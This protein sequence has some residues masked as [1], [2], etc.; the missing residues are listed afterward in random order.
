MAIVALIMVTAALAAPGLMR[1]MAA[2]RAQ[3]AS[4]DLGRLA[5]QARADSISYGR[6]YLLV[7]ETGASGRMELWRGITDSCRFNRWSDIVVAGGCQS[8]PRAADCVDSVDLQDYGTSGTAVHLISS[9][10]APVAMPR[11]ICFEPDDEIWVAGA[12][13]AYTT[14]R[15]AEQAVT[16]TIQRFEGSTGLEQRQLL[17]PISGAPRVM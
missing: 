15:P 13:G 16:L 9:G 14:L 6:A 3:R 12:S 2:E 11:M 4:F 17:V 5:R 7:L 1:T 10:G 8:D